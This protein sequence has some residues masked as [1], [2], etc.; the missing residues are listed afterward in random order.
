MATVQ[1]F[2][3][4]QGLS[5]NNA[6]AGSALGSGNGGFLT[7]S[8]TDAITAHAGG[9]QTNAV[10]LATNIN[11][12]TTVAT[13]ADSVKLPAP[14]TT[15]KSPSGPL[16]NLGNLVI[17]INSGANTLAVFPDSGSTINGGSANASISVAAGDVVHFFQTSAGTWFTSDNANKLFGNVTIKSG[18]FIFESAGTGITAGTTRT[19]AGATALAQEI[20]RVDTSTA[21]SAG[22]ILGDGVALPAAAAGLDLIVWNNTANPIQLYGNGSDTVNGTA[23]ATG[24]AMPPNSVYLAVAAA[25]GAWIVDGTGM[26]NS[27][28][29]NTELTVTGISAAGT[30]QGTATPLSAMI[31]NVTTVSSGTGV[32]LPTSAAGLSI[33]VQNN[34]ANG[35]L[36][37]P[38]QGASDTINGIAATAGVLL[39]PGSIGIF[40]CAVAGAW[41]V[42]PASTNSAAYT[43]ASNTTGFTASAAQVTGGLASVDLAL[44]GTLGAGAN[45]T[46]PTAA[47]IVAALHCPTVGTSYRL[48]ITNRSGGAFSW[49][50]VAGSGITLNGTAT[51]AQNTWREFVM[52]VTNAATPAVTMQSVAVGT[53][54]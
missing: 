48:R 11:N 1:G 8:F 12:I 28:A 38:A 7:L 24:I 43:T 35:L 26:G 21:P 39:L 17:V 14:T 3:A 15:N 49:T 2:I 20:N 4:R 52:T 42:Q 19:Q 10:E 46:T 6:G 41:T 18:S 33:V 54:S 40:N 37:Y 30:T 27:G 29:L 34:G 25:T 22:T 51:I 13:A 47:A 36:V 31:N 53:Y 9:A 45:I 5:F 16:D 50:V 23:G 44:T 32:N